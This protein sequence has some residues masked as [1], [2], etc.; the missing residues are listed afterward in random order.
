MTR[1]PTPR[2]ALAALLALALVVPTTAAR[3]A[4]PPVGAAPGARLGPPWISIEYPPSPYDR[5]TRD[6][7]LLVH[8]FH[9]GTPAG[10]P[11]SGTAEGLVDGRRRSVRLAFSPTARAGV[12]ALRK[13]WPSDGAWA[14]VISVTQGK[15]DLAATALV[16]IAENGQVGSVTVPTTRQDG[17]NIPRGVTA[18]EVEAALRG[19]VASR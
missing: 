14:L 3:H 16:Q 7:Y 18:A 9:H 12:Y 2:L 17:W 5:A 8:A 13:Q 6:A 15:G 19:R 1:R 4:S 11:V 10:L